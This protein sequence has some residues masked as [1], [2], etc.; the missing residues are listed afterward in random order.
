MSTWVSTTYSMVKDLDFDLAVV[1]LKLESEHEDSCCLTIQLLGNFKLDINLSN[2]FKQSI[3]EA[4]SNGKGGKKLSISKGAYP[5]YVRFGNIPKN[6]KGSV[7]T[8]QLA[9]DWMATNGMDS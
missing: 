2:K 4:I 1:G 5:S 7:L 6:F 9:S 3:R 8:K